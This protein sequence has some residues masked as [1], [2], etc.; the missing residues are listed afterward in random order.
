MGPVFAKGRQPRKQASHHPVAAAAV[1]LFE[2]ARVAA[3]KATIFFTESYE[4][5]RAENSQIPPKRVDIVCLG[6]QHAR[7]QDPYL[8][9][10]LVEKQ[11]KMEISPFCRCVIFIYAAQFVF[12]F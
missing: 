12:C 10:W 1:E 2:R 5:K 9:I 6:V 8:K 11:R 7:S 4:Y 3:H